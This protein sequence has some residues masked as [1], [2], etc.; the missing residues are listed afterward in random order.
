MWKESDI[1]EK[2]IILSI[3]K[4]YCSITEISK[5]LNRAKPTI[6]KTVERMH[7]QDLLKKSH[8][9]TQDARKIEISINPKR[10]KIEK[11]HMFYLIYYILIFSSLIISGIISFLIKGIL[12]L[13]GSILIALPLLIMMGYDVYIKED[14][15]VVYKDPKI[16]K[17]EEK[18]EVQKE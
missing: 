4:N 12:F 9:Y 13:F 10:I 16:T 14:K 3:K 2:G 15:T 11:S 17:K 7:N 8:K 5:E 1:L 18:E 6:S